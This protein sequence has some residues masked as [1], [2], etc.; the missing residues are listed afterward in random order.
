VP[1][2][3]YLESDWRREAIRTNLWVVPAFGIAAVVMLFAVTYSV[4]RAAYNGHLQL[5]AWVLSGTADAARMILTTIAAALITV[6][7]IVFSITIVALTLASTQ[8]GPR[9]LRNFVRDQ[10]TQLTLGAFVGTFC[11]SVIT[12]VSVSPGPHGDF[13]PHLSITVALVMTLADVG[14]LIYFLNHIATMIQLPVVIAGIASTLANEISA[15]ERGGSFGLGA[16]RGPSSE[17]LLTRLEESGTEIRTP[18]SGYLQVIR[19][20]SLVK[21]ATSAEAVIHLPYRPGHFLVAGQVVARVWPADAAS[22]VEENL[23]RGHI[24]GPYRTLTQDISFGFDQLVEIALRALS[25]AVNDTFTALTCIDWIGDCLCRISTSWRPQRIRRD[26]TGH[27][28][29]IAYQADFDR[30]VERAF[31]KIR[32]ASDGMPAVMI[33][34][35]ESLAKIIDQTPD[36][37]RRATLLRQAERI[38]RASLRSVAEAADRDD[39]TRRYEVVRALVRPEPGG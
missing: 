15:Q 23:V 11:Y 35:L 27:I 5:P 38:Q 7:G 12:L 1:S 34:Q 26:S 36:S 30:L 17:E 28:R 21:I 14:V 6:V 8:F 13:V 32:Q 22:Y 33:R 31:E 24:T 18:R 29:V 37:G 39:V 20:E 9:M 3:A 2:Y 16:A 19:N 25:P 10:G 4:D